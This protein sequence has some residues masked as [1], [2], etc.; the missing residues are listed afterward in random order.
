M[1]GAESGTSQIAKRPSGL[2]PVFVWNF[3][4]NVTFKAS[5]VFGWP[6]LVVSVIGHTAMGKE[7]IKGY[8]CLNFPTNDGRH[9]RYVPLYT[10]RSSSL[11]LR[12]TSWF[13][14]N[15][16]EYFEPSFI[17]QGSGRE[18]TRVTSNGVVKVVINIQTKGMAECGYQTAPAASTRAPGPVSAGGVASLLSPSVSASFSQLPPGT[19]AS[20]RKSFGATSGGLAAAVDAKSSSKAAAGAVGQSMAM[21]QV[22]FGATSTFGAGS[23]LKL[24]SSAARVGSTARVGSAMDTKSDIGAGLLDQSTSGALSRGGTLGGA[25]R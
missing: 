24:R 10:P 1:H 13:T 25:R 5:N 22:R 14:N 9:V 7:V 17:A 8:G 23:E 20:L 16:P 15:P 12:L 11:C 3:P 4:L 19:L 18:T 2:D 21:S 6:R